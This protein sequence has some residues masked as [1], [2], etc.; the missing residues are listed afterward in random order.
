[1]Q[2]VEISHVFLL[3]RCPLGSMHAKAESSCTSVPSSQIKFKTST[4]VPHIDLMA[5]LSGVL[6][7][8]K[9]FHAWRTKRSPNLSTQPAG[10]GLKHRQAYNQNPP[11]SREHPFQSAPKLGE[12]SRKA[13][14]D[15]KSNPLPMFYAKVAST[16]AF[17]A[18]V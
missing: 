13:V 8:S 3:W 11:S 10:L 17:C 9:Q 6:L 5:S 2:A 12:N 14:W 1:M 7:L 18:S 4:W 16:K 15:R